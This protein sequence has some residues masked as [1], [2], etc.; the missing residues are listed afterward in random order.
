MDNLKTILELL[1]YCSGVVLAVLAAIGLRQLTLAKESITAVT[2]IARTTAKRE[3]F[4]LAAEQ[5]AHYYN[6]VIPL[7]NRY[8]EWIQ[9]QGLS[10]TL[11]GWDADIAEDRIKITPKNQVVKERFLKEVMTSTGELPALNALEGMAVL[12]TSGVASE[13]MAFSSIGTT[14][15]HSVRRLLP[16]L[17]LLGNGNYFRHVVSLYMLWQRRIER[18][19]LDEDRKKTEVRLRELQDKGIKP[20]GV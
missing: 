20:I 5:C 11:A 13:E 10:E 1:Y 16:M 8:D 4:R 12:F 7:L 17:V 2:T 19:Q 15:C 3:A 6:H 18:Q 9:E 14:F